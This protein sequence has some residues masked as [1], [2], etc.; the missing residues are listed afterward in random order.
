M[1]FFCALIPF[2]LFWLGVFSRPL[3]CGV[4]RGSACTLMYGASMGPRRAPGSVAGALGVQIP[5]IW[6]F[7]TG[8][9]PAT[10]SRPRQW[11]PQYSTRFSCCWY[12]MSH[13]LSGFQALYF[14]AATVQQRSRINVSGSGRPRTGL[15]FVRVC[16]ALFLSPL[17]CVRER[18]H[19]CSYCWGGTM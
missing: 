17:R 10:P 9:V 5:A 16:W 7:F 18:I 6:L 11:K 3:G 1:H 4:R 2:F 19:R 8:L 15:M 14:A 12:Y 13:N